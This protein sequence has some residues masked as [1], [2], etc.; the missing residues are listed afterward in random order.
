MAILPPPLNATPLDSAGMFNQAW[1][2]FFTLLS[3]GVLFLTGGNLSGTLEL[4]AAVPLV[5]GPP[6]V[7]G[8]LTGPTLTTGLGAPTSAAPLGSLYVNASGAIGST[9]YVARGGGT[10]HAVAGV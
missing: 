8:A 2:R 1:S 9:L 4:D 6:L 10:W 5:L 7:V 3:Q